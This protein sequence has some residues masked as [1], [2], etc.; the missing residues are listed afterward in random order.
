[1]LIKPWLAYCKVKENVLEKNDMMTI[2][3]ESLQY[4]R[5]ES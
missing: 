3:M 1:M 5:I 4:I 2:I